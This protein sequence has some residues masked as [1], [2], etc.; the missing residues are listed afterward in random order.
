[1][2]RLSSSLVL[3]LALASCHRDAAPPPKIASAPAPI[4]VQTA[5]ATTEKW[6][7][8]ASILG[9]LYPKDQ[10]TLG[11]EIEG[12]VQKTAVE[13]GDRITEGQL[14]AVIDDA[15]YQTNLQREI[16]NLARA[17]ANLQNARQNLA[18][19]QGLSK[20]GALSEH[21]YDLA[22]SQV[23]QWEA[24]VKVAKSGVAMAELQI[25]RCQIKAPFDGAVSDRIVTKGD[26]VKI[27]SPLFAVVND[28]VLKYIFEV[29]ERFGSK[30]EKKL[31]ISFGVD[32]YPGEVFK[33]TV[34]LISPIVSTAS[35]AF[36]VGALVQNPDLRLKASSFARGSLVL[37][38]GVPTLTVPQEAV[39]SYAGVTKVYVAD[40]GQ[41]HSRTVQTGRLQNGR[42]EI[43]GEL[44]PGDPVIVTG[45]SKIVEG[46]AIAVEN[47]SR[48]AAAVS[49]SPR[50]E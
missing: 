44:K 14:L 36:N 18:R 30:V 31:E 38:R 41:A 48:A 35:R 20:T 40:N 45:L 33:G 5:P 23:A 26:Y 11:A 27:G 22:T 1:M 4:T 10:A 17:E 46:A 21:D 6:D 50:H 25:Q 19:A 12:T 2:T 16:G 7:Q 32:N 34:Y 43:T 15:T 28:K 42:R 47:D 39:V 49:P 8:T 37:D 29:P 24:E 13:F 3:L 9:S